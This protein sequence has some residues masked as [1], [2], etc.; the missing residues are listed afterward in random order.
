[1]IKTDVGGDDCKQHD[2]DS[3]RLQFK[4]QPAGLGFPRA[5]F[6]QL[7]A[8]PLTQSIIICAARIN[9]VKSVHP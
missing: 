9:S 5:S 4:S 3:H 2:S 6:S 1:M 7:S 8:G